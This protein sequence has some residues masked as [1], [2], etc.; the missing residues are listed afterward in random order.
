MYQLVPQQFGEILASLRAAGSSASSEKRKFTRMEVHAHIEVARLYDCKVARLYTALTKDLSSGGMGLM[1]YA[2][3]NSGEQ[4]I[5]RLPLA[6][7]TLDLV[8]V[9]TFSK[10]LAEGIFGI[11]AEF[12]GPCGKELIAELARAADVEINRI[13]DSILR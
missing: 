7:S 10:P 13:K 6:K 5:V 8:A 1:Q 11:G 3:L 4:F 9:A 2:P 12:V